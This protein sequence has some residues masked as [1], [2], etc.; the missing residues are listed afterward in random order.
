MI[1][2]GSSSFTGGARHGHA[3][4]HRRVRRRAGQTGHV[5]DERDLPKRDS[6]HQVDRQGVMT[7]G[8]IVTSRLKWIFREQAVEDYGVDCH[9]E[10]VA[11]DASVTGRLIASRR[12]AEAQHP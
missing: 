2:A 12:R 1:N 11:D 7:A 10:V 8:Y 5:T 4:A 3:T 9:L 6:K